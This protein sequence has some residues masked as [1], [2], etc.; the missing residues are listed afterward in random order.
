MIRSRYP[1]W[2]ARLEAF[3]FA[4]TGR[5]FR[6]GSFDCC[7]FVCDAIL[8]MTGEDLGATFRGRY[9]SAKSAAEMIRAYGQ[10][11]VA[12]LVAS[13]AGRRGMEEIPIARAQRGDVVLVKRGLRGSS[14]GVMA[15]DGAHILVPVA[16]G[17]TQVPRMAGVRAWAV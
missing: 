14:L 11:S 9:D 7:L 1:D 10:R 6:Y 5:K 17:L 4:Q 13:T 8:A 12:G 3:L 16:S 15:L 2:P